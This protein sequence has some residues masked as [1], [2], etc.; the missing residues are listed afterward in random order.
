L[1][2]S[3]FLR[4]HPLYRSKWWGQAYPKFWD[5]LPAPKRFD[6]ERRNL[7]INSCGVV[8]RFYAISHAPTLRGGL[9]SQYFGPPTYAQNLWPIGTKFDTITHVEQHA[10]RS[11]PRPRPKYAEPQHPQIW[12]LL[13]ARARYQK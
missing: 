11:Q 3:A 12:D 1:R 13:H 8:A 6:V 4:G 10:S 5:P 7:Y 2:R 9:A